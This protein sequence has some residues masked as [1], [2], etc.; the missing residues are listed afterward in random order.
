MTHTLELTKEQEAKLAEAAG[1]RG[2]DTPAFALSLIDEGLLA[3]A[4]P[5][6]EPQ[7]DWER[8]LLAAAHPHQPASHHLT[9]DD[10]RREN[11]YEENA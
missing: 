7:D 6:L 8:A 1:L 10:L 5:A 2:L 3:R 9:G 11:I 4:E